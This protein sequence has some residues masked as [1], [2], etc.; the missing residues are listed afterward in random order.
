M[1]HLFYLLVVQDV[2]P[3]RSYLLLLIQNEFHFRTDDVGYFRQEDSQFQVLRDSL[4]IL[5]VFLLLLIVT[6]DALLYL[7]HL[8]TYHLVRVSTFFQLLILLFVVVGIVQ[9]IVV[10]IVE[11]CHIPFHLHLLLGQFQVF[12]TQV[13]VLQAFRLFLVEISR[14]CILQLSV[15][16]EAHHRIDVLHDELVDLLFLHEIG[17]LHGI[18]EEIVAQ[19]SR[20]IGR[21]NLVDYRFIGAAFD[22]RRT[23]TISITVTIHIEYVALLYLAINKLIGTAQPI[24]RFLPQNHPRESNLQHDGLAF[25]TALVLYPRIEDFLKLSFVGYLQSIECR[26]D[27][28]EERSFSTTIGTTYQD[29]GTVASYL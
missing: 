12:G 15:F 10:S 2:S 28:I 26:I 21:D 23:S 3:C 27:G 19:F 17:S 24:R 29:D 8:V 14:G 18:K 22:S 9:C 25:Y 20:Q 11:T 7:A 4:G 16:I 1:R 6:V 5:S 13:L